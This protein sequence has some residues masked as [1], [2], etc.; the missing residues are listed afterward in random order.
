MFTLE[1]ILEIAD[2]TKPNEIILY[3]TADTRFPQ[4]SRSA[5]LNT[6]HL[7]FVPN[8]T[9]RSANTNNTLLDLNNED[10]THVIVY[11][12]P[13]DPIC[14]N[15][16][17]TCVRIHLENI[18]INPLQLFKKVANKKI[19]IVHTK[20]NEHCRTGPFIFNKLAYFFEALFTFNSPSEIN[21]G[22]GGTICT[23]A[24]LDIYNH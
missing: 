17:P 14:I 19:F 18:L 5:N 22:G 9:D 10:L 15:I 8:S 6:S 20:N 2:Q 3:A 23:I 4:L 12:E 16:S 11:F 1:E 13:V 7:I 24:Y 21:S